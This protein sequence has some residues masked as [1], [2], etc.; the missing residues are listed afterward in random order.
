MIGRMTLKQ[1]VKITEWPLTGLSLIFMAVYAWQILRQPTGLAD[2]VSTWTMNGLWLLFAT[3]YAV[4][5]W[6]ASD[7]WTW[8]KRHLFDFAVVVLPMIRPLRALRVLTA[9]NALHRAGGVAL[10]GRIAMY[11]TA[12]VT[13]LVFTGSLAV[14]DAE[15]YAPHATITTFPKALWWTFVTITTVGYG[16]YAPVTPTGRTIAFAIMLAGI[17]LIGVVTATLAAWIVDEVSAEDRK[18]TEISREQIDRLDERLSNIESTLSSLS[19]SDSH[20]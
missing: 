9:L 18:N 8:F 15:R 3:D 13:I 14:L 19:R 2:Q 20:R 11:V 12:T 16:D 4:S 6:L 5:V 7:K 10:R 17:A 1:W